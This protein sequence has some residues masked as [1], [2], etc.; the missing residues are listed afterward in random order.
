MARH[1]L[2]G[3]LC[4]LM[5]Q[6]GG[7]IPLENSLKARD[8][9]AEESLVVTDAYYPLSRIPPSRESLKTSRLDGLQLRQTSPGTAPLRPIPKQIQYLMSV[10]I[11][12]KNWS[13]IPDTGSSDTWL[14]SSSFKCLDRSHQQQDQNACNFGPSYAG[15]FSGGRINEHMN[16]SYGGGDSLNGNVGYADITVAGITVQRQQMAL[17]TSAD[18]RGN[19]IFSGILGLGMRGLTTSYTGSDPSKDSPATAKEYA[20]LVETMSKQVAPLFSVAMSR[21]EGRSFISFGGVP[22]NVTTGEFA[23]TP[24][25]QM[26]VNGGPKH[27]MY[28]GILP[29]NMRVSNTETNQTWPQPAGML[30]D[31][32][33]TLSYFPA[34]VAQTINDLFVPPAE[35]AGSGTFAVRCDAVPPKVEIG[36][37]GKAIPIHPSNLILPETK[38]TTPDGDYCMSGVGTNVGLSILGDAFLEELLVVFDISDKKQMKFAQRTDKTS[39]DLITK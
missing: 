25:R 29:D 12:G 34:D 18:I 11:G 2:Q 20:P 39:S 26:S 13:M 16:I 7:S 36:I 28:Y 35:Y 4:W 10:G 30:V 24:I 32:G 27:Y 5:I 21:D 23:T 8:F 3:L 9:L 33:T 1:A 22:P 38:Q 14:M 37:G 19:G 15:D 17:V 6:G 31:T